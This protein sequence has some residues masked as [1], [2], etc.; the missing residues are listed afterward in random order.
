MLGHGLG[1]RAT[2]GRERVV[3]LDL[4][5]HVRMAREHGGD[6]V[7]LRAAVSVEAVSAIEADA[8]IADDASQIRGQLVGAAVLALPRVGVLGLGGAAIGGHLDAVAVGVLRRAAVG[9]DA[10]L[11]RAC[12]V[13]I[14]KSVLVG[15]GD[16]TSVACGAG[17]LGAAI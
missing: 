2:G 3:D 13:G 6:L 8:E 12:I 15:V 16:R 4:D 17:L 10:G 5:V 1:A 7:E 11:L 14:Q 9:R